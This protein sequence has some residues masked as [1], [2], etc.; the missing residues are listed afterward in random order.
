[1]KDSSRPNPTPDDMEARIATAT[2]VLCGYDLR[3]TSREGR[4]P[5]CGELVAKSLLSRRASSAASIRRRL[6]GIA[7]FALL[8]TF[9][10]S[11]FQ[12]YEWGLSLYVCQA[13]A[14]SECREDRVVYLPF[15]EHEM[16]E[17]A[18]SIHRRP[19]SILTQLLDPLTKCP[20][21]WRRNGGNRH[22]FGSRAL[23]M[24]VDYA[25]LPLAGDPAFDAFL[26]H[27]AQSDS[28]FREKTLG[29]LRDRDVREWLSDEF[30]AHMDKV[31]WKG[32]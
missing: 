6:C 3:G 11:A 30:T 19:D 10:I 23:G 16:F 14:R 18:E 15:T 32:F 2:C 24:G 21:V 26:R 22:R 29:H 4:C 25:A 31:G 5:E 28:T 12:A 9:V 20:H 27:M 1:M 13:C 8:L 7:A 17:W